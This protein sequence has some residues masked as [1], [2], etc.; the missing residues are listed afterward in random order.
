MNPT[1][2]MSQ[3]WIMGILGTTE[4]FYRQHIQIK[5]QSIDK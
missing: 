5:W 3:L 1:Q 2:K 4:N